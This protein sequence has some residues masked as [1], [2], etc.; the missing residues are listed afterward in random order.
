VI[1]EGE[2]HAFRKPEHQKDLRA[3]EIGWFNRYLK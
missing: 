1:Y 3:R 2:G